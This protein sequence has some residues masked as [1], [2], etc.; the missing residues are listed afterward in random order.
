M[1]MMRIKLEL[2]KLNNEP[3]SFIVEHLNFIVEPLSFIV[4]HLNFIVK[5]LS[6]IVEPLSFIVEHLNFIIEP[7][8]FVV[9]PLS[10]KILVLTLFK[11]TEIFFYIHYQRAPVTRIFHHISQNLV[12]GSREQTRVLVQVLFPLPFCTSSL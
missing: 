11:E 10:F 7:L 1:G 2:S 8:S 4:E 12:Q 9:E 3:L 6:F 5:P